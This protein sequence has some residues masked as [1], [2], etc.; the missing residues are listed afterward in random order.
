MPRSPLLL[1][2]L[3]FATVGCGGGDAVVD[4]SQV[5][6][7]PTPPAPQP[8]VVPE[9]QLP[10]VEGEV[11]GFP[12]SDVPG[13]NASYVVTELGWLGPQDTVVF[14]A[15][16]RWRSTL[17][18]AC[19]IFRRAQ[20]GRVTPLLL[21]TQFLPGTAGGTVRH[22]K[23]PL[24]ANGDVVV[25][26]ADVDGGNIEQGL[27]A[28]PVGGGTP[29]L[30]V[31]LND[32]GF[33]GAVITD[34]GVV[35][36]QVSG[37]SGEDI[38]I[39][40]PGQDPV[41]LCSDCKPGFTTDGTCVVVRQGDEAVA[42]ELDGVVTRLL[43]PGDPAP[44]SGGTVTSVRAA[45]VNE[46]GTFVVHAE[47]DD[48]ARP[49]VLLR[50]GDHVEVLAA[51][52]APAPGTAGS[53]DQLHPA[54]GESGDVVFGATLNGDPAR[55]AA[56]FCAPPGEPTGLVASYGDPAPE[57][58]ADLAVKTRDVVAD[59]GRVAFGAGIL[60]GGVEVAEGVF[61]AGAG[62]VVRAVTTDA[63]VAAIED[64]AIVRFMYSLREA[65]DVRADGRTLVHVGIREDRR[66]D[67]TLGALMLVR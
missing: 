34:T 9:P 8:P 29:T 1:L 2:V 50:L 51:C 26:P 13:M 45:W 32:G 23:L 17:K 35:V 56:I 31:G 53:F 65:M 5:A 55:P 63:P 18:L 10:A 43:G 59:A 19:G 12:G 48:P 25:I 46:D 67:A 15:V 39:V 38:L 36:A 33:L 22:P 37:P 30:L 42:V 64:A 21:Q 24:V 28:I 47:T 44:G 52:G 57:L 7:D 54:R 40:E 61:V 60:E 4:T 20:D 3:L 16:I 41:I 62:G 14:E 66:P 49:D 58:A 11:I 27:F 6:E